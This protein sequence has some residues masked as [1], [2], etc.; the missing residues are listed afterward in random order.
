MSKGL[1][2]GFHAGGSSAH[3]RRERLKHDKKANKL[4]AKHEAAEKR[5][6][7]H[8]AELQNWIKETKPFCLELIR[9][10]RRKKNSTQNA[11]DAVAISK[12]YEQKIS[13]ALNGCGKYKL[14]KNANRVLGKRGNIVLM[15]ILMR[16][17]EF[18]ANKKLIETEI[19]KAIA[20]FNFEM[21]S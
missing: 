3:S 19:T 18:R 5:H 13:K 15:D 10:L 21:N 8:F 1:I 7:L 2:G 17:P 16:A 11:I 14:P 9:D 4:A 20:K 12:W 6:K